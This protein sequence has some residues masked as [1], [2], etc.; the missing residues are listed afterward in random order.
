LKGRIIRPWFLACAVSLSFLSVCRAQVSDIYPPVNTTITGDC[1][2]DLKPGVAV[3]S[4]GVATS[5]LKP[6]DAVSQLDKQLKLIRS[7]IQ[8]NQGRLKELERVRMIHTERS[9]NGEPRGSEFQV[10]QRFRAEFPVDAAVDH[11]LEHI[12]ELGMDRFGDNMASPEYR[13]SVVVIHFEIQN[14]HEQVRAIRERC[15]AQ[16]WKHWCDS[17]AT[18]NPACETNTPPKSLRIQSFSLR[19]TE[20]LLR[21]DAAPDYFLINYSAYQAQTTPPELLG[22]VPIHLV[23]N[24]MLDDPELGKQ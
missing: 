3:I 1:E 19:S 14:F 18:K 20:K 22:N 10:A 23:G 21:S 16:A 15:V 8:Q 6:T 4:G 17:M 11:L 24:V 12:M 7:Y 5:A 13:Q 9:N 2:A